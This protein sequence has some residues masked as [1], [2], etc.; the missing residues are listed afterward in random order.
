MRKPGRTTCRQLIELDR[1]YSSLQEELNKA[2]DLNRKQI[3]TAPVDDIVQE[4]AIHTVGG[5][6]HTGAGLNEAGTPKPAAGGGSLAGKTRISVLYRQ[7]RAAEIKIRTF[8]FTKYGVIEASVDNISVDATADEKRGLL[9]KARLLM[10]RNSLWVDGREVELV[11][12]MSISAEV[13]TGKRY[14]I[15]YI[16]NAIA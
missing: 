4:L 8:P 13:K 9:Y 2:R 11:P 6:C 3:L 15:E 10:Q 7:G 14:L 12:G 16:F 1:Q 5:V